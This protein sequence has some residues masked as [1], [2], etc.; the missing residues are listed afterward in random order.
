[1]IDLAMYAR[2]LSLVVSKRHYIIM[3]PEKL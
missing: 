2:I 3:L 1:M